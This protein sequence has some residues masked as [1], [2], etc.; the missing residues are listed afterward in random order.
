METEAPRSPE[1][2][3]RDGQAHEPARRR[4]SFA[5]LPLER[6]RLLTSIGFLVALYV[7][8]GLA[9]PVFFSASNFWTMSQQG[10]I[11]LLVALGATFVVM[12]GM[13]D[14]SVGSLVTLSAI[15]LA[16]LEPDLGSW[17][18]LAAIALTV[19]VG[20][21]NGAII[22]VLR[23]PSFLV[24]IGTLSIIT[25]FTLLIG[26]TYTQIPPVGFINDI[27]TTRVLGDV[28]IITIWAVIITLILVWVARYTVYGRSVYA[29]GG[30]E[31][32]SQIVGLPIRRY[33]IMAF[34]LSGLT[35]GIA[36]IV[37]AGITGAGTPGIGASFLLNAIAAIAVGGTALTGGMGGPWGTVIGAAIITVLTSG[38]VVLQ[39]SEQVQNIVQGSVVI[40]AVY[41]TM[42]RSRGL[43]IK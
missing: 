23:I 21:G 40:A 11:L 14:L 27:S 43:I 24:T 17:A 39:V 8:F 18:V 35:C 28:P 6:R 38:L 37:L 29:I 7:G 20:A 36:G 33:K 4:F 16:V 42:D 19:V 30:G 26:S 41:F 3:P 31:R 32:V 13:I 5:D 10:S 9:K 1:R 2:A 22:T 12:M 25:G 34:A 15:T